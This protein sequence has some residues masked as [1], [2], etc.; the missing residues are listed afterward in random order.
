MTEGPPAASNRLMSPLLAFTGGYVDTV[1]FIS[2]FG[3]FTAH[4]TGNFVLIGASLVEREG[5]VAGKLL[6]LPT[7]VAAVALAGLFIAR[8]ARLKR[9][10]GRPLLLMQALLLAGFLGCGLAASAAAG[11]DDW[12]VILAGCVGV[13]AMGLQNAASRTVFTRLAPSTVMTGNVTQVVLDLVAVT[14]GGADA[15]LRA[16]LQS[17]WPAILAFTVGALGGA[18]AFAAL[19]FWCLTIAIIAVLL[20][21]ALHPRN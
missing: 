14:S 4:V 6:A 19:G 17:M 13:A 1:G 11:P 2:L 8:C 18:L 7:F 9:D 15:A 5:G 16:R 20:T 10:A 21:S 12:T 3:L